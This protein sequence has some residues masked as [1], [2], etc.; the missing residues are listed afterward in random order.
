MDLSLACG[1]CGSLPYLRLGWLF[2]ASSAFDVFDAGDLVVRLED[3][4]LASLARSTLS[5]A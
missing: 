3:H 5:F 4:L 2:G 1:V